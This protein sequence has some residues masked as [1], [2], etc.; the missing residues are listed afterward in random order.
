MLAPFSVYCHMFLCFIIMSLARAI[1]FI[2]AYP[3]GKCWR[4]CDCINGTANRDQEYGAIYNIKFVSCSICVVCVLLCVL[5][6]HVLVCCKMQCVLCLGQD[7]VL[8][9]IASSGLCSVANSGFC[10]AL[11]LFSVQSQAF[12]CVHSL[13]LLCV[14]CLS[15]FCVQFLALFC[16]QWLA[17]FCVQ[18][19]ALFCIHISPKL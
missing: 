15:V 14:Q 17:V 2:N 11:A 12:C 18:F 9:S 19:L 10:L 4:D 1:A 6:W 8:H 7:F 5:L 3:T 13:A 16:V